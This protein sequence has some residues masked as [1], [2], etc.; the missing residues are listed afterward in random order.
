MSIRRRVAATA[1]FVSA[2]ALTIAACASSGPYVWVDRFHSAADSTADGYVFGAGDLIAVQVWDHP[3]MSTRARVRDDG[4]ISVPF[5]GDVKVV[6]TTPSGLAH[7]LETSLKAGGLVVAPHA[8]ISLEERGPIKIS[9]LGEVARPGLYP[10]D[11]GA[12][13]AEA[14]ASA[15][16]LTEFA[17]RDRIFVTRR[18]PQLV[19][20]RFTFDALVGGR[21]PAATFQL[22]PG[23]V[24]VAE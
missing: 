19:R 10:L 17:R 21:G 11:R 4:K 18:S 14:L 13:L 22:Q 3:E 1:L 20:I 15:G 8:T 24:V 2:G 16:G 23:D 12:G 7:D 5:L 6:G 9:V